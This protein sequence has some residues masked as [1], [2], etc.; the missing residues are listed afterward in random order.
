MKALGSGFH[1][2]DPLDLEVFPGD[3]AGEG[4][5]LTIRRPTPVAVWVRPLENGWLAVALKVE[6]LPDRTAGPSNQGGGPVYA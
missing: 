6:R 1:T 3:P 2:L 4:L 5:E